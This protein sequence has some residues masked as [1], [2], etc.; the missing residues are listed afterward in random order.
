MLHSTPIAEKV[1]YRIW[2]QEEEENI[3]TFV[4]ATLLWRNKGNIRQFSF[5]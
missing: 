4:P 2:F 1:V 5:F 3:N